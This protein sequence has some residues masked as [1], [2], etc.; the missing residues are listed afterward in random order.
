VP[1]STLRLI[2]GL[3]H[4]MHWGAPERVVEAVEEVAGAANAPLVGAAAA[5]A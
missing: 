3:G 4:M 1:G 5:L 2:P